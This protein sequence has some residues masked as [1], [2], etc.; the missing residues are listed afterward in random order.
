MNNLEICKKCG[1]VLTDKVKEPDKVVI[2][3]K[4]IC[5]ECNKDKNE[6]LERG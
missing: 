6:T 2:V 5:K 4:V 1:K 3:I